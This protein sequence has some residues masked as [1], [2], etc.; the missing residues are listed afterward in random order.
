MLE[1][2][3]VGNLTYMPGT[4]YNGSDTF[5]FKVNQSN[6]TGDEQ[7]FFKGFVIYYKFFPVTANGK[8]E[9]DQQSNFQS[10]KDLDLSTNKF[11]RIT[12]Y[13]DENNCE[14]NTDTKPKLPLLEVHEDQIHT[15]ER[16]F[17]PDITISFQNIDENDAIVTVDD[18]GNPYPLFLTNEPIYIRRNIESQKI[19]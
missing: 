2:A 8:L 7:T 3:Y 10:Y 15:A 18:P 1:A 9:M 14:K 6:G 11:N 16:S 5:T 19:R 4:N 13:L 17:E 12:Y